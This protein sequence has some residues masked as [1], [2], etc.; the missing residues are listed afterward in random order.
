VCP[1]DNEFFKVNEKKCH[2]YSVSNRMC[3]ALEWIY[4]LIYG[5][6]TLQVYITT[7]PG[8]MGWDHIAIRTQ[9]YL[10]DSSVIVMIE[11]DERRE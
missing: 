6:R 10:N 7:T 8:L 4:N 3:Y 1:R 9:C 2:L 11:Y 5:P